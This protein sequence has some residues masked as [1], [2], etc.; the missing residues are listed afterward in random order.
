MQGKVLPE[1]S[2]EA[3]V[4]VG[5][6]V[7]KDW[8]DVYLHPVGRTMRVANSGDGLRALKRTLR[9]YAVTRIVMEAT[10]KHHR[11]AFRTLHA[12]GFVTVVINPLRSRLFAEAMGALA[13][14][15]RIDARIL[16]LLGESLAP[17]AM[18]PAPAALEA[19]QELVHARQA[20]TAEATALANR[21]QTSTLAVLRAELKRRLASVERHIARLEAEIAGR[22][23]A[24]PALARRYAILL[25]IPGIGP[26]TASALLVDLAELGRCSGRAASLLTGVAPIACDSGQRTGER[27]IK[28]GRAGVR[29]ALYMAAIAAARCNPDLAAFYKRLRDAGKKPKIAL[30][31]VMRKLV[32]LANTLVTEDRLWQPKRA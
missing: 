20:A 2:A 9:P 1:R 25:Y 31:A 10:G 12:A 15:D 6:D 16:A 23:Q 7:C 13:K 26:A 21:R 28:G 30:V 29:S 24:D 19:L 18:T 17:G 5:I 22:I 27:H 3:S 8:L 32:I 4:Y 14:T 11:L